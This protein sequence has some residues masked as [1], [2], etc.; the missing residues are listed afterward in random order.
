MIRRHGYRRLVRTRLVFVRH[1]ESAHAVEGIVGGPRAC[2]GLTDRG[3]AQAASLAHRL[4]AERAAWA[5]VS[6][7]SSTLPRA[8]E[9]AAPIAELLG[10]PAATDCGLCTWHYTAE[11]D[12]VPKAELD[13]R[14]GVPGGGVFRPF[15]R[16]AETWAELLVRTGRAIVDIADRHRGETAILV[17]HTETVCASFHA[18]GLLSP[19]TP[20]DVVVDYGS[21]TDWW[22]DDD[23]TQMPPA[24]WTLARLN[25]PTS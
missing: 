6:V 22:T 1:G 11:V 2:R 25:H 12:G 3:R 9:T 8:I 13:E 16:G 15:Q 17:A 24:R 18:L 5:D 23:P 20:F 4:A 19:Y 7:Y 10:V 21:L 14:F